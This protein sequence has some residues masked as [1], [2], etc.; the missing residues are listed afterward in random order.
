MKKIKYIS[1]LI[2]GFL[3]GC[4]EDWLDLKPLA[5]DTEVSFYSNF[6]A[7][8]MT[9]TAT[10]GNLCKDQAFDVDYFVPIGGSPSDDIE[11]GGENVFDWTDAHASDLFQFNPSYGFLNRD[12]NYYY[13]GVKLANYSIAKLNLIEPDAPANKKQL[14]K[15]RIAEM[16]FLRAFYHFLIA[17]VFGGGPYLTDLVTPDAFK[18]TPRAPL[19]EF[20]AALEKDLLE[21]IPDLKTRSELG[22]SNIGRASKGAAQAL[23]GKVYLY[24]SSYAE[25][26]PGVKRFEGCQNHYTEAL[27][28][29]E[30]VMNS[31]D[32]EL[33]GLDSTET[34]T[35]WWN[36]NN[37]SD[38]SSWG[39]VGAYRWMF[40]ADADNCKENVWEIQHE[41]DQLDYLRTR[42]SYLTVYTTARLLKTKGGVSLSQFGW[43]FNSPSKYLEQAFGNNDEREDGLL[44]S[45]EK[46]NGKLDPRYPVT[47]GKQ[48]DSLLYE[49]GTDTWVMLDMSGGGIN[50]LPTGMICRKYEC[51]PG[52]FWNAPKGNIYE[53]GPMNTRHIRMGDVYLMAA[54][55]A[56]KSGNN[57]KALQY[58]NAVRTR[59]RYS[60]VQGGYPP[61]TGYPKNLI[62]VNIND[63]IHERRIEMGGEAQRFFDL[64][65]WNKTEF[66]N[67][68]VEERKATAQFV[69]GKNEFFPI[70]LIDVQTSGG[71]LKQNDGY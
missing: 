42:G 62:S 31:T 64:V 41:R 4:Q 32:Y 9:V 43:S 13:V 36:S 24:E 34:F 30:A 8:D 53:E 5:K 21:A 66:L 57:P 37:S 68:D 44:S 69:K 45:T 56:L 28:Q 6:E 59:A 23:L 71:T 17:Q 11:N 25:N 54:E 67:V 52:E 26:Y 22:A 46:Y 15:Q 1:I 55:A 2:V 18:T 10:Y 70:P 40:T 39:K 16:K 63:I 51:S 48:G 7:A 33:V 49:V 61:Y 3:A 12:W 29:L 65:R 35:S 20:Y 58:I 60:G 14:I 38:P 27:T 19:A 47:I 50:N